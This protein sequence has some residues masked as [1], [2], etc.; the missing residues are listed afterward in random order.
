M[1]LNDLFVASP[2]IRLKWVALIM[3]IIMPYGSNREEVL[4]K[5]TVYQ[6]FSFWLNST[7]PYFSDHLLRDLEK[8]GLG[9]IITGLYLGGFAR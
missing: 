4:C 2:I 3:N 7:Q 8:R 9:P 1:S 6:L 5:L